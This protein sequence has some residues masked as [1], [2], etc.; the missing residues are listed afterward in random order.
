VR[1]S[2]VAAEVLA[3]REESVTRW[4]RIS[5][6]PL[7]ILAIAFL[8]LWA[9]QVLAPLNAREWDLVEGS[10]IIIW[11]GFIVDFLVRLF[12][13]Q[14]RGKFLKN[15]VIEIIA[16]VVPALRF[17]RMLRVL[18]AV[19][20]LTRVVQSLQARVNLYIAIVLPMLV[21][22]GALGVYEAEHANPASNLKNF[23]DAIWWAWET[24][25]TVGYGDHFPITLEGRF[26]AV[27]LMLGGVAM[28]SVVTANL[29]SYF[30]RQQTNSRK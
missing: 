25:F 8:G 16:L 26:I 11:I 23:G 10:I 9:V 20:M 21:F 3:R 18:M 1:K 6:L 29:A 13:H 5:A 2:G 12:Y 28:I 15:N 19:G 7:A 27:V 24:V 4:E 30:L 14:D 17:L 22:A